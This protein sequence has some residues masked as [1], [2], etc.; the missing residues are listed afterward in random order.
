MV[1]NNANHWIFSAPK[2]DLHCH[3]DG[4]VRISTVWDLAK[5]Q[6]IQLPASNEA[7]LFAHVYAGDVATSLIEYL[8]GFDT[9]VRVLQTKEALYRVAYELIEDCSKENIRYVEVRY[10]PVRHIEMG[11]SPEAIVESVLLGLA[12]GERDFGVSSGLI[13]CAFRM[14]SPDFSLETAKLATAYRS[15][16]VVAF[17]LAGDE[18]NFPAK[19]HWNAYS[20]AKSHGLG[21]TVHAGEAAGAESIRDALFACG[22]HRLGHGTR[23]FE[24]TSL[25][26]Y[27]L[28]HQIP[29]EVCLSSNMQTG[30]SSSLATHPFKSYFS[31]NLLVTLNTDNRLITNTSMTR[32]LQLA[33]SAFNLSNDQLKHIICNGVRAAFLPFDKKQSM[34]EQFL[35]QLNQLA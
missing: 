24:D 19:A 8:K 11:L 5:S 3:L 12:H 13:L 14:L 30:V 25:E 26:Q 9:I 33:Q 20:W 32:E 17:D 34:F 15:K 6:N 16:G 28:D 2:V 10:A 21:C 35:S 7:E 4:S 22:A 1:D 18:F 27:V 29:L 31:K 23:L